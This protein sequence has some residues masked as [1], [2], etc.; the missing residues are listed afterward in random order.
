MSDSEYKWLP[1]GVRADGCQ[2]RIDLVTG[3][4]QTVNLAT[5]KIEKYKLVCPKC[6][7]ILQ[8]EDQSKSWDWRVY[9]RG[10][11]VHRCRIKGE[12]HLTE[13]HTLDMIVPQGMTVD[14]FYEC[15][16]YGLKHKEEAI[17][18]RDGVDMDVEANEGKFTFT[19]KK[20]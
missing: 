14:D 9:A 5:G 7:K 4:A 18:E 3:M 16:R 17:N 10:K 19:F 1:K 11:Y 2:E 13:I 20:L 12:Q 8:K 15:V 6:G